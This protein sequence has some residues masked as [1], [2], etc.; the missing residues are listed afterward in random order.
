MDDIKKFLD[1]SK[2]TYR[3]TEDHYQMDCFLCKDTNGK[4]GIDI[5]TGKWKC[6][7]CDSHGGKLSTFE[8]AFKHKSNIA[9]KDKI[10]VEERE[11]KCTIKGDF[12]LKF[13]KKIFKTKKNGVAKY[14]RKQR[15]LS[16]DTIKHFKLGARNTFKNKDGE[17]Y[18]TD[19]Y[20]AI[21]YIRDGKCVNIKYRAINPEEKEFKWRREKG[22]IS[23]LFN[24][25]V[26]D[27]LD[28]NT[29]YIAESEI[30]CMSLHEMGIT[31]VIGLTVGAKGFKQAWYDRLARFEKIYLVLDN[32]TVGQ[33]GAEKLAHRLGLHRC[34]NIIL[35]EDTKDPNDFLRK[36]DKDRF[37][38]IAKKAPQFTVRGARSLKDMMKNLYNKRFVEVEEEIQG[39]KT[40]WKRINK[41]IGPLKPGHLFILAGKPKSGKSS[42]ALNLMEHWGRNGVASGMWSGEMNELRIAEKLTMMKIS[43]VMDMKDL[44]ELHIKEAVYKLPTN[45]MQFYYPTRAELTGDKE[46]I[47]NVCNKI[48]E[49]VQRYG[50]KVFV[51]DNLHFL[52]RGEDDKAMIDTATQQFKLMAEELGILFILV[53]HPRKTNN[54]KQL[55]TDDLKGSSSIFQDADVVWLQHRPMNDGDMTPDEIEAGGVEGSMSPLTEISV[56]GRWTDG[57]KSFLAFNGARSLFLD[58]GMMFNRVAEEV[59]TARKKGKKKKGL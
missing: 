29:I 10:E 1:K 58:K 52:C 9:T 28:H 2:V 14:V 48:T 41:I 27:N 34:F 23:A 37:L 15:K 7:K 4:L 46:A 39:F 20:L 35:P 45:M 43:N 19:D 59:G 54:N 24:D 3:T 33:E 38:S 36:Y 22:G 40:P 6:F 16:A 17:T 31:N 57:G 21:P 11:K 25:A 47:E 18:T 26:I 53:T 51:L 12:H 5:K 8:Y 55:K 56:T 32:D 49:I 30:D 42:I 50:L 44:T 13:H